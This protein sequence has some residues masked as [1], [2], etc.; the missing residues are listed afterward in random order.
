MNRN[1]I[2]AEG[3]QQTEISPTAKYKPVTPI[4]PLENWMRFPHGRLSTMYGKAIS[5]LTRGNGSQGMGHGSVSFT[6]R[7]N[8]QLIFN[9]TFYCLSI[10]KEKKSNFRDLVPT[11]KLLC[12]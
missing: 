9:C 6:C 8:L 2:K 10:K 1:S 7:S 3:E 11:G 12:M 5:T 4:V